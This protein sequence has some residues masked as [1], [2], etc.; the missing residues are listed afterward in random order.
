MN[1]DS[2]QPMAIATIDVTDTARGL[3]VLL[4]PNPPDRIAASVAVL[5]GLTEPEDPMQVSTML[6]MLLGCPRTPIPGWNDHAAL[7]TTPKGRRYVM[8]S[9]AHDGEKCLAFLHELE[10]RVG[11]GDVEVATYTRPPSLVQ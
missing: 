11:R 9:Y 6:R 7:V 3:G 2:M 4:G 8:L 10:W 5:G 1:A